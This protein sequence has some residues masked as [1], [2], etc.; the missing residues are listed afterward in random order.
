MRAT[1]KNQLEE[2]EESARKDHY[3]K[4]VLLV[5]PRLSPEVCVLA[6]AL[7]KRCVQFGEID[8]V[9]VPECTRTKVAI[10]L[11]HGCPESRR[12]AIQAP[13]RISRQA[14]GV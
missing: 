5:D 10:I 11:C 6:F 9:K 14:R 2:G 7:P 12:R 13:R 4:K 1:I 3:L 8:V